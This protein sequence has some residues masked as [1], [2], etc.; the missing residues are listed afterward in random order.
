MVEVYDIT[1]FFLI[2]NVLLRTLVLQT[3]PNTYF[4]KWGKNRRSEQKRLIVVKDLFFITSQ[5]VFQML[6]LDT[7]QPIFISSFLPFH[8]SFFPCFL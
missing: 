1:V 5:L 8:L 4:E 2:K 7:I 3:N 6:Y